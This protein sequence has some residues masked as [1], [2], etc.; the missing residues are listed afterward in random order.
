MMY[1]NKLVAS[2]KANGKILRENKENVFLPFGKEYTILLKN[3]NSVRAQVK[4]SID[5][6]DA[7]D[8]V[9]LVIQPNSELEL[10]RFI[11]NGNMDEGN[12]F[13]FIERTASIEQHRGSKIDDGL[14]RIEF[15]FEK[16]YVYN[17]GLLYND[18]WYNGGSPTIGGSVLRGVCTNNASTA[19]YSATGSVSTSSNA[20][21][22]GVAAEG[23]YDNVEQQTVNNFTAQTETG[24][25]VPG[26]KTEQKFV[27]ASW[28]QLETEKHVMILHLLGETESGKKVEQP[29]TVKA[30]PKC[31]TC[32]KQN[33]A[34]AKFCAHC[35]TALEII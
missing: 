7:T 22:C 14:I 17:H 5:G 12:A 32:G 13:K 29:I 3:L 19:T 30:K 25:T 31:V 27:Q 26:S 18:Y 15:Q 34:N 23:Q 21:D 10:K 16:P 6:T 4:I 9:S 20:M 11:K 24:I 1:Q 35:G 8:G 2:I 28:F 33:K